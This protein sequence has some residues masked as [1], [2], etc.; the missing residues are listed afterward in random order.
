ME[1]VE[2]VS[3]PLNSIGHRSHELEHAEREYQE[4]DGLYEMGVEGVSMGPRF[5]GPYEMEHERYGQ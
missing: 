3:P 2:A 5:S 1:E 4:H